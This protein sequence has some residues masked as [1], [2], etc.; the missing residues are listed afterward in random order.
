MS[1]ANLQSTLK[2][3]PEDEGLESYGVAAPFGE[4]GLHVAFQD[5]GELVQLDGTF[6]TDQ[7]RAILGQMVELQEHKG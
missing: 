5:S 7:L 2:P 1:I 3:P 4:A 6:S